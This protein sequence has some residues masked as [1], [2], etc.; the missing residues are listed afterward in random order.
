MLNRLGHFIRFVQLPIRKL[1]R[2]D[3]KIIAEWLHFVW[4]KCILSQKTWVL[5]ISE[6]CIPLIERHFHVAW[7]SNS[8]GFIIA[9]AQSNFLYLTRSLFC[10]WSN[11][12]RAS[13]IRL[14]RIDHLVHKLVVSRSIFWVVQFYHNLLVGIMAQ[15]WSSHHFNIAC[16]VSILFHRIHSTKCFARAWLR[17]Y[18][19]VTAGL[20]VTSSRGCFIRL[21]I[22][23]GILDSTLRLWLE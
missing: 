13:A 12:F 9:C 19:T 6:S 20:V 15:R 17:W 1:R 11:V 8:G 4:S 7:I 23:R 18:L 22:D 2:D 21:P 16:F 5:A 14:Y 3:S 10:G